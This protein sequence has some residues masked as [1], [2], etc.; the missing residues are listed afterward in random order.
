M[1]KVPFFDLKKQFLPLREEILSEIASVCDDQAFILGAKVELLEREIATMCK[2][3]Y[4]VGASSGTDAQ[5]LILMALGIGAGDAVVTT[6]FTFFSTAGCIA[7][8]GAT[9][10]F[11]DVDPETFN[12]SPASLDEFFATKCTFEGGRIRTRSGLQVKA[13]IPVHLFG[14][15]CM[16][17]DIQAICA[18]YGLPIIEDAA[19]AIGAEYPSKEGTKRAGGIGEFGYLSFYPTKNLG[20]FGDAGMAVTRHAWMADRLKVL[21]NH[22]MEQKYYHAR[23]GGNFRLDTLQAAVLLKKLPHLARW[24]QRR[25]AIAQHYRAELAD[26]G[27]DLRLP[28]EPF[29]TELA[30]RGHIHNQFV[31]RAPRRDELREHLKDCGIGTEIYYPVSLNRQKCFA[32]LV[33]GSLPE[34]EAAAK[35]V[36]AL[37]IFPELTDGEVQL[38]AD[39][40][41]A[42]FRK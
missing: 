25:W 34:S 38:V 7:R 27:P 30:W 39:A 28:A 21:R 33:A 16:M 23:V 24:S 6:P 19:Q 29:V 32:Y 42:F 14:L 9:P 12:L 31:V 1:T 35:Q 22:G 37:P 10:V 8:L 15:C 18:R 41:A 36:L 3:D 40:V 13:V 26:F 5:L 4:A 17:D 20:A 11:V 2:V